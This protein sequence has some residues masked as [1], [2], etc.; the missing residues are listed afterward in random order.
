MYETH[1]S[2]TFMNNLCVKISITKYSVTDKYVTFK[3]LIEKLFRFVVF[4]GGAISQNFD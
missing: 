1:A 3:Y 2:K 4:K